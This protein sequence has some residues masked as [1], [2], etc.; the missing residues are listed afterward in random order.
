[1]ITSRVVVIDGLF[2]ETQSER[3]DIEIEVSLRIAG[4][5]RYVMEAR[6]FQMVYARVASAPVRGAIGM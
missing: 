5:G 1:M 6:D 3:A 2:D 4:D